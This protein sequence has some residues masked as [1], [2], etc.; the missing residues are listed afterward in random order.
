MSRVCMVTGA[1]PTFGH[2]VSHS[3]RRTKRRF[4]PNI[5]SKKYYVPS[6]GR[7]VSLTVSTRGIKVI[8]K[9]GIDAVVAELT[10]KGV[11]F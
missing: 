5:Q 9:R 3:N 10:K 8:D 2:T 1:K 6:L 4:D 11:S 7:T